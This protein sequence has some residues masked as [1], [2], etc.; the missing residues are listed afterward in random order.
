VTAAIAAAAAAAPAAQAAPAVAGEFAMPAGTTV[1]PNNELV[2]GPDGNIW[3]TTEQ[4]NK[5]VRMAPDGTAVAFTPPG[6]N[7][8][9]TGITVGLNGLLFGAQGDR[10]IVID[11]ANP[12]AASQN[13]IGGLNGANAI[14]TGLDGRIWLA[15]TSGGGDL[16][17][18][19]PATPS[20]HTEHFGVTINNPHG[21]ATGSDGL[22][23]VADSD[24]VRSFT[25]TAVPTETDYNVG[26]I[27]QDIA[28]GPNGQAAFVN[29]QSNPHSLGLITPPASPQIIPLTTSDPDGVVFGA[30]GAYWV[31]RAS[32]DDLVRLTT[33]GQ[34]SM[35]GGFSDSGNVGPRKITTG[36]ADTLWVTL[37]TQE[38]V[39]KVTGVAAPVVE[40]P[41]PPPPPPGTAPETTISTA[42]GKKVEAKEKT[43]KAKVKIAFSATGTAPSFECTLTKKGK[44]PK[45]KPCTSPTKYKLKPGKYKFAVVAT[46]GGLVDASPAT[47]KFKVVEP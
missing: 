39:A 6:M 1:G 21:M 22:L 13:A 44:D 4:N 24:N 41:P 38:K 47:T 5:I 26:G 34:V 35:L 31:A 42:P 10:F 8:V 25:A 14:T 40:P 11:P 30:D 2:A 33:D 17:E 12:N 45:T 23:W 43:G 46:V 7:H 19:D 32:T 36:P 16:V 3:I 18:I 27:T 9:I 37:D 20:S 15:A 29:P 28:A